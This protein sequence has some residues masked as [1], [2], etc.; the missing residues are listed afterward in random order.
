MRLQA[1]TLADK[2]LKGKKAS[3]ET[4]KKQSLAKIGITPWNKG[5]KGL[6]TAWNKGL[7]K[8]TSESLKRLSEQRKG[9]GN[10]MYKKARKKIEDGQLT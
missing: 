9:E 7:T 6:Q 3:T 10:P 5:K 8:E 4:R 1:S 2:Y